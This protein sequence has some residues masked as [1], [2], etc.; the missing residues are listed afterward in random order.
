M[1]FSL[2]RNQITMIFLTPWT[3]SQE[4]NLQ[5][6]RELCQILSQCAVKYSKKVKKCQFSP[7]RIQKRKMTKKLL[8]LFWE[9][10]NW[11]IRCLLSVVS[12]MSRL[13]SVKYWLSKNQPRKRIRDTRLRLIRSSHC[14]ATPYWLLRKK[15]KF[16]WRGNLLSLLLGLR[17]QLRKKKSQE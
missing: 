3:I 8:I 7:T 2:Q 13:Y 4:T 16:K 10:K 15:R 12:K 5:N 9:K 14:T 1:F 17:H 11:Q 6:R